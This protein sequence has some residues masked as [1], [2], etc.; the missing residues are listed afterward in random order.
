MRRAFDCG[1]K[2]LLILCLVLGGITSAAPSDVAAETH[3]RKAA[4][5]AQQGKIEDAEREY[6]AGLRTSPQSAAAYNN[7]GTLYFQQRQFARAADAFGNARRLLPNDSEVAFNLGLSLY[8]LGNASG[9]IPHLIEGRRSSHALDAD[10]LLGT[11]YFATRQWKQSID[12]LEQYRRHVP[13]NAQVLFMLQQAYVYAGDAKSSLD[14]AAE[15]LKSHPESTYTHQMLGEAY[16]RDGDVD[17]A[18]GE[19]RQ[20]IAA[21]PTAPQLHFMLGYVYWRWKRYAEAAAPLEEET[22][23]NPGFAQSYFYLGDIAFRK[24]V[25]A[26]ALE[27]FQKALHLDPSYSEANLGL[28][29]TYVQAGQFAE[30]IAALR[31]A[32][33]GLEKASE[34]HYWLGRALIQAGRKE[35]GEKELAKVRELSAAQHRKMQEKLNSV[36]V[37]ERL[38]GPVSR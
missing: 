8:K 27:L 25:T 32:E 12:A 31:K 33:I 35:E 20:G 24:K 5:L 34:V 18:A 38:Q 11:C 30:G 36:P 22:R 9:A 1:A 7:L 19:F 37:G 26:R 16:D 23:I 29:K 21:D 2:L 13:D 10:L 14:A 6:A 17:H 4:A 28:G 3:F 15:L